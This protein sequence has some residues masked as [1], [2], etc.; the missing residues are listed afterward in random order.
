MLN[1]HAEIVSNALF[2]SFLSLKSPRSELSF[3]S[4]FDIVSWVISL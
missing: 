3:I 2:R 1:E 4:V